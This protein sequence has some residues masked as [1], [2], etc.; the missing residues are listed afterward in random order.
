M[1]R[2]EAMQIFV[3]VAEHQSFA[4]AARRH[5]QSAARVTRAVAALESRVGAVRSEGPR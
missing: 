1:D 4:A 5:A 2:F 3:S